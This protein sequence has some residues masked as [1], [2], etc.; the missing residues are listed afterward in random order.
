MTREPQYA[1][2]FAEEPVTLG[3]MAGSTF[4]WNPARLGWVLA[5]YK[6]VAKML[7]GMGEVAEIGCADGF[8]SRVVAAAVKRLHLFDFDPVWVDLAGR[9]GFA[10]SARQHDL[11]AGPIP[12]K[13]FDAIYC[14]DVLEHIQPFAER[15]ALAH[16]CASLA[17]DGVFIA[18]VPSL[19]SQA[20]AS[21]ISKAGH[22]NCRTGAIFRDD[23]R[24]HFRNV[25]MF[26]MNDEVVHT[27]FF[28]M[29]HYLFALCT[30]P[31]Q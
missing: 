26:G 10:A 24:R 7:D 18:G 15:R 13:P 12:G 3:P 17:P 30:G 22:V 2:C 6:F 25:F 14:L 31:R 1:A 8:A 19:E 20:Y 27:G 5:R 28:P 9:E 29:C 21:E 4:R 16:V 11:T 23:M